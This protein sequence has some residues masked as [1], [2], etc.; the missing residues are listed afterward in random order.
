MDLSIYRLKLL[1]IY[2][3][4]SFIEN[5]IPKYIKFHENDEIDLMENYEELVNYSQSLLNKREIDFNSNT[6]GTGKTFI[7]NDKYK[8]KLIETANNSNDDDLK[9]HC[10]LSLSTLLILQKYAKKND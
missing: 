10:Y 9:I 7:F 5:K 2:I 1:L 8:N 4:K 3:L 6:Y